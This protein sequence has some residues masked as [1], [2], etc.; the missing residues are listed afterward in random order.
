MEKPGLLLPCR[1]RR[2]RPV[3]GMEKVKKIRFVYR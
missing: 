2:E 1:I 3:G